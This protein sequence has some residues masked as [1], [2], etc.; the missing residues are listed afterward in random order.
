MIL[1]LRIVLICIIM[2]LY[3]SARNKMFDAKRLNVQLTSAAMHAMTCFVQF[4]SVAR[5]HLVVRHLE[6]VAEHALT[7]EAV[8]RTCTM[9]AK[10]WRGWITANLEVR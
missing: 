10:Y 6:C 1:L 7:P 8:R 5:A 3:R 4:P 2:H 9:L